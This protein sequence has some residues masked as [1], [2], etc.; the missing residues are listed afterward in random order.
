MAPSS[1]ARRA[2]LVLILLSVAIVAVLGYA[3]LAPKPKPAPRTLK[4]GYMRITAA[5]PFYVAQER[6]L[7]DKHG[8]AVDAVPY[9]AG[10]QLLD[11]LVAGKIDAAVTGPVDVLLTRELESPGRFR[12]LLSVAYTPESP[13]FSFVV[14]SDSPI[15]STA[16]VKGETVSAVPGVTMPALI[17]LML[18][19]RHGLKKDVDYKVIGTAPPQQLDA[20]RAKQFD[21]LFPLEPTGTIAAGAADLRVIEFG[22]IEREVM[23]PMPIVSYSL[24]K[25]AIDRDPETVRRY[26]AAIEEAVGVIQDDEASARSLLV[27]AIKLTP[28]QAAKCGIGRFFTA[29]E[30]ESANLQALADLFHQ[31][32]V[33]KGRVDVAPLYFIPPKP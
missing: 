17:S 27:G 31:R 1:P 9:N 25:S 11:D 13:I 26:A 4:V 2:K 14:R 24:S 19:K 30:R 8:V 10:I 16:D 5:L 15:K 32:G 22:P 12:L 20:L 7:F 3:V 18:E 28:E 21:A 23:S 29:R 6:E 33:V